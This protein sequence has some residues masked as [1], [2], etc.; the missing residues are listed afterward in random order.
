MHQGASKK[1]FGNAKVV[2]LKVE[3]RHAL[4]QPFV[5]RGV[6]TRYITSGMRTVVYD[7]IGGESESMCACALACER[8][9]DLFAT[10]R[11]WDDAGVGKGGGRE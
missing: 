5:A 10:I 8:G 4:A 2:A 9:A 11:S 3:L 7:L 6:S 1:H